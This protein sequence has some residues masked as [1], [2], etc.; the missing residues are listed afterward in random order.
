MYLR[1]AI[2]IFCLVL[3]AF[4]YL[5]STTWALDV[6]GRP[7]VV[8]LFALGPEFLISISVCL[9]LGMFSLRSFLVTLTVS[10][11]LIKLPTLYMLHLVS[12]QRILQEKL[13]AVV[14][15]YNLRV[16][17]TGYRF[18]FECIKYVRRS[19]GRLVRP[20]DWRLAE[21][22]RGIGLRA[23][24]GF[25]YILPVFLLCIYPC[26]LATNYM[27]ISVIAMTTVFLWALL[28]CYIIKMVKQAWE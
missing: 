10:V 24:R 17:G 28:C 23:G 20:H 12:R 13:A 18:R 27:D 3:S 9:F 14:R 6:P 26:W 25:K 4:I 15:E 5:E 22:G 11:C 19:L 7:Q 16:G 8:R 2:A 1:I 21:I